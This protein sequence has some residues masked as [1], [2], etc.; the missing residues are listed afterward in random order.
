MLHDMLFLCD[1]PVNLR[2]RPLQHALTVLHS[3]LDQKPFLAVMVM[4]QYNCYI[5]ECNIKLQRMQATKQIN[6]Y[7]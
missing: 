2:P 7:S 6:A 1:V 3:F 4:S 5:F